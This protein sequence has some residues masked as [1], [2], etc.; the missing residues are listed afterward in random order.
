M[1]QLNAQALMAMPYEQMVACIK[2]WNR[3]KMA[4]SRSWR[5]WRRDDQFEPQGDWRTWLLMTGR[6]FG[7]GPMVVIAFIPAAFGVAA[8]LSQTRLVGSWSIPKRGL[9]SVRCYSILG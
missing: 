6:G 2:S 9:H 3:H 1:T 8:Q 7:T 5:F 4:E